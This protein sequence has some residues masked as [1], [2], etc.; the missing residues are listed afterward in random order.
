M[1]AFVVLVL[2]LLLCA[3]LARPGRIKIVRRRKKRKS[4]SKDAISVAKPVIDSKS[5]VE[6]G[7]QSVKSKDAEHEHPFHT[8]QPAVAP[9]FKRAIICAVMKDEDEY[10]D[11]WLRY[12][13]HLGFDMIQLYD[14]S[15]NGSAKLAYL[16][17]VYGS[18]ASAHHLPGHSI[19]TT[20][21][22]MCRRRYS[23]PGVWAAFIDCDEFIVLRKHKHILDLL[24]E[25]APQ[26]GALSL[27]RITFGSSGHAEYDPTPVLQRFTARSKRTDIFVK[28]ISH[29]PDVRKV[30]PHFSRLLPDKLRIDCHGREVHTGSINRAASEDVAAINH[31][32]T[33]SLAEFRHKRLRGDA[34]QLRRAERYHTNESALIILEEFREVDKEAN[35]LFD[36]RA[37]EFYQ[38]KEREIAAS[39]HKATG[40]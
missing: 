19:Q 24:R 23:Q 37:W 11:E 13:K 21:Y 3:L 36:T 12:H 31:Y 17:Q 28:T 15:V 6:K 40:K 10:V 2:V 14:N 35:A 30:E 27:N 25:H 9:A 39:A 1:R 20:A 8:H 4:N 33:K 38:Q 18:F 5:S 29:L 22:E 26:G 32:Y 16:P 34:F 7:L